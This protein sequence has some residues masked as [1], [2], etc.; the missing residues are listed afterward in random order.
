M[1]GEPTS[2]VERFA[3]SRAPASPR[4]SW[5]LRSCSTAVREAAELARVLVR[6][7][8]DRRGSR[9]LDRRAAGRASCSVPAV[10]T[11][12]GCPAG[13]RSSPRPS[14]PTAGRRSGSPAVSSR[15]DLE[16]RHHSHVLVL[17]VG[18]VEDVAEPIAR[19]R[20]LPAVIELDEDPRLP[21]DISPD[22]DRFLAPLLQRWRGLAIARQDE[23]ISHVD[24]HGV[25]PATGG[26]EN[27][28]LRLA[29]PRPGVHAVLVEELSVDGPC[30]E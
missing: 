7:L 28:D 20:S 19:R 24:V 11:A 12:S 15:L 3:A 17:D 27:P 25:D 26:F 23:E 18:A 22:E 4:P 14:D 9:P 30:A 29:H 2:R 10:P 16:L 13:A 5:A 6:E 1:A 8:V 21:G